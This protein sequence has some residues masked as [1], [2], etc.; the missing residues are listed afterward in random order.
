MGMKRP[1]AEVI[2]PSISRYVLRVW[3]DEAMAMAALVR[4]EWR[5]LLVMLLAL[6]LVLSLAS[7]TAHREAETAK[8]HRG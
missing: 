4:M 3:R 1:D 7:P 5:S 8:A 2:S 6:L